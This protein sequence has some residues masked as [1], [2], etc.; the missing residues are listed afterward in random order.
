[1]I[2]QVWAR[3]KLLIAQGRGTLVKSH[4][5]QSTVLDDEVLTAKRVQPYGLSYY[6]KPG[7]EVYMVFP[8]GNRAQGIALVVGDK[9]Y[10]MTLT[11]G[12]VALHDDLGNHV[13]IQR[14]GVI[15]V[16][17]TSKVIADTPL[18]ETTG[19]ALIGGDLQVSGHITAVEGYYG[20]GGSAAVM[21][22]GVNI[23]GNVTVNGRN[24]SDTHTHTSNGSGVQTSGVN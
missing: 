10:Q 5:V 3:V 2:N 16:T 9:R 19:N 4:S 18:F 11:E 24:V 14:G 1:M 7:C 12:E 22:G 6:P 20:A 8:A 17:A 15:K 21:Q 13:H 23:I